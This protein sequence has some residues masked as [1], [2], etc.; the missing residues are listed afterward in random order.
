MK[1]HLWILIGAA[2][3]LAGCSS[4]ERSRDTANPAVSATTLA[5]QVCSGCHGVDGNSVSPAFPRLAGQQPAYIVN[6][7]SGYRS[8]QRADPAGTRYMWGLSRNMTDAQIAEFADYFSQQTPKKSSAAAADEATMALGKKIF[9]E[10]IPNTQA[11]ACVT[12][13]GPAAQGAGTFP[14][15]A[16][17]HAD[18]IVKQLNIF[19][20]DR[21][22]EGTPMTAITH[23]LTA[24]QKTAV[25]SYLQNFP[26]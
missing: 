18:Y 6:Q 22:R 17:Q 9:T 4:V 23:Q 12:C 8:Q 16:Y 5:Q 7:L 11:I 13:H 2:G 24:E 1:L 20:K 10:G 14:R 19:Q 25:A 3:A 26:D 15:L 21:G